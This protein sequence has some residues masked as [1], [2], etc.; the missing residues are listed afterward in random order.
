METS[1]LVKISP[2][3][4][5]EPVSLSLFLSLCIGSSYELVQRL[6]T[7]C[8]FVVRSDRNDYYSRFTLKHSS[9]INFILWAA[10]VA[11]ADWGSV[12]KL[13]LGLVMLLHGHSRLTL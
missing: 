1:N 4:T 2:G 13:M 6:R 7:K 11:M 3:R 10:A 8:G 5:E 9:T 12:L